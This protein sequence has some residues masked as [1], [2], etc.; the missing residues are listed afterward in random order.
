MNKYQTDFAILVNTTD[1][2]SDCWLPFFK[3]FKI[4]WPD[5]SG[6]IYLN[7]ET[8][9]FKYEG[10]NIISVK[11][12]LTNES[13]S[14]CLQY[15][16]NQIEEDRF[17]YMQEDYFLH[18]KVNHKSI[19]EFYG[20]F[21]GGNFDCL[22]LTDQCTKGPFNIDIDNENLWEIKKGADY[23]VSTQ[24]AF[25]KKN[26]ILNIIRPWESGWDFEKFGTI[27]SVKSINR[28]MCVNQ[29]IYKKN[30]NEILPYIFTGIIK[31]K[32]KHE[33][34]PLFKEHQIEVDFKDR[35]L[36]ENNNHK[37]LSKINTPLSVILKYLKNYLLE[38]NY[39]K[40]LRNE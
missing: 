33:V 30:I 16:I 34:L 12:G 28:I 4:F 35:G 6:K 23:R 13:W 14:K 31:G 21:K 38:I 18:S 1:S 19:L 3:L 2:F 9:E 5:Y 36:V 17:I 24:A 27:R 20:L 29:D 32:W 37:I 40:N 22:H 11:S 26:T 25:W 15:A 7:T 39:Q 10:L 8:K